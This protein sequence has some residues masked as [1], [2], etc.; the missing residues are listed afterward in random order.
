VGTSGAD[1][2][3]DSTSITAGQ[4]VTITSFSFSL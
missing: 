3:L 2:N 4:S 1:I